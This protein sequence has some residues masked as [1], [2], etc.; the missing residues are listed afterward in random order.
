MNVHKKHVDEKEGIPVVARDARAE[1][2]NATENTNNSVKPNSEMLLRSILG[3]RRSQW[4]PN[5]IQDPSH[6]TDSWERR[7]LITE[8]E[9]QYVY[10][11]YLGP[12]AHEK[13]PLQPPTT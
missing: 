7:R 6:G 4:T 13:E 12:T 1:S 2:P 3:K 9:I 5:K 8:G 11:C 10:D